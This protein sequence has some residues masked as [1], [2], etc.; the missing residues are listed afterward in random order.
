[1]VILTDGCKIVPILTAF[2]G[3]MLLAQLRYIERAE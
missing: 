2:F 1:M 3:G